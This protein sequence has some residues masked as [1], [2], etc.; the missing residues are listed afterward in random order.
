METDSALGN[1]KQRRA[2][3]V[4]GGLEQAVSVLLTGCRLLYVCVC[5]NTVDV[6]GPHGSRNVTGGHS[7][8]VCIKI[9][10]QVCHFICGCC[11]FT[12]SVVCFGHTSTSTTQCRSILTCRNKMRPS[13]AWRALSRTFLSA[14]QV[15]RSAPS[16]ADGLRYGG[17]ATA[18]AQRIGLRKDATDEVKLLMLGEQV[19][20]VDMWPP[21]SACTRTHG[22]TGDVY[23]MSK[24][25]C[26]ALHART[27][28]RTCGRISTDGASAW[29]AEVRPVHA[30]CTAAIHDRCT[31][32][33]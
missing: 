6:N 2:S 26:A 4:I 19:W 31:Q 25:L 32:P 15:G 1:P 28:A 20:C 29:T 24:V 22:G 27:A 14:I 33:M 17:G 11:S 5:A 9:S 21:A 12:A 30:A 3:P 8:A 13:N 7:M 23:R 10:S 16:R 18:P